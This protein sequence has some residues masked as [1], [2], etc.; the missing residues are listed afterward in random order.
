VTSGDLEQAADRWP[1]FA[2][3]AVAEGFRSVHALPLRHGQT[4]IGA[5]NLFGRRPELLEPGDVRIVQS[6]AD[7]ATIGILQERAI[8][9]GEVLTEQLQRALNS[10]ITIEQAKGALAHIHSTDSDTAFA[11]LRRYS[12][13]HGQRLSDVALDVLNSPSSHPELTTPKS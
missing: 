10:R 12:R 2:P 8:R 4:V 11:L 7:V 1:L 9:H 13:Q 5:L 6:L 3:R